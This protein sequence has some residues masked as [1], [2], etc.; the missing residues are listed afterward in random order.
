MH[1]AYTQQVNNTQMLDIGFFEK[2]SNELIATKE[3]KKTQS[4]RLRRIHLEIF[5]YESRKEKKA[6]NIQM[7]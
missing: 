1:A 6:G 3:G 2:K 7:H 4:M 5:M